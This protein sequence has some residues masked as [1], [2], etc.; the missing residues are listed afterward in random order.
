M[1][2][3]LNI[4]GK[5]ISDIVS[6]LTLEE[7]ASFCNG[8]DNWSLLA[9]ERLQIPSI[10]LTDGPNGLRKMNPGEV[11]FHQGVP[12]TCFPASTLISCSWD[13]ELIFRMG[14]AIG[15]ECLQEKVFC[16]FGT[17]CEY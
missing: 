16:D 4:G 1:S 12:A 17:R 14:A 7:K 3:Q 10:F 6:Q 13:P 8:I 9:V 15:E 5:S 11:K 2:H